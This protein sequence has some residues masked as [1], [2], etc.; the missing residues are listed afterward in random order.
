MAARE[1]AIQSAI[2]DLNAGIYPSQRAAAAAY[3]LP[4]STLSTRLSGSA[5]RRSAHQHQQ[6]LTPE[7][8][9]FLV[10]WILEQDS[11][12]YP[13]SHARAREMASRILQMNGDPKPL[14]QRWLLHFI[15]RNPRVASVIGRKLEASRAEAATPQQIRAFIELFERVRIQLGIPVEDN[16]NM[17]ETGLALGVCVNSRVLANSQKKKAYIKSPENREWVSIIETVSAAGRKLRCAVIFKGQSLQT[18]WFPSEAIPDWL[19]TT[20][21]NGWTSKAIG[22]EWLKRIYIPESTPVNSGY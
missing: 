2:A 20:S 6:R 9:S 19:Y 12:G 11:N 8:E 13:P 5:S 1:L 4:Q 17:D 14:G 21:E 3:S 22:V 16:W 15:N 10:D 7:Q 18:T